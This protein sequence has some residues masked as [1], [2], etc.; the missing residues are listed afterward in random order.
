M[1]S[2][3]NVGPG[4]IDYIKLIHIIIIADERSMLIADLFV[5]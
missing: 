4:T 5:K 3:V 2:I 1:V